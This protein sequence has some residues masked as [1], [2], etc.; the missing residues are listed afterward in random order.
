[1]QHLRTPTLQDYK[2]AIYCAGCCVYSSIH[3]ETSA[4]HQL[5]LSP[6]STYCVV[7]ESDGGPYCRIHAGD[8][9]YL[10][11]ITNWV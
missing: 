9:Y 7:L 1:M 5:H 2:A 4:L 3:R 10:Q 11:L 8:W 6:S